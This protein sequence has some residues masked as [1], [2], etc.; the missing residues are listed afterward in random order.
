M[1]YTTVEKQRAENK[2]VR[3]GTKE[4][5]FVKCRSERDSGLSEPRLIHQAIQVNIRGGRLPQPD[6]N[7]MHFLKVPLKVPQTLVV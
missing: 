3:E 1:P 6:S 5:E 7:G 2:H 4:Q